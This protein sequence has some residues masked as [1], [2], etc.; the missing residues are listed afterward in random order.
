VYENIV[1][2]IKVMSKNQGAKLK[3]IDYQGKLDEDKYKSMNISIPDTIEISADFG[4]DLTE[5]YN[6][7]SKAK[8]NTAIKYYGLHTQE[9]YTD[10][11]VHAIHLKDDGN[12]EEY[13]Y[14]IRNRNLWTDDNWTDEFIEFIRERTTFINERTGNSKR[15][16]YIEVHPSKIDQFDEKPINFFDYYKKFINRI[17]EDL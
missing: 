8:K 17:A 14:L 7:V 6:C 16:K 5:F 1:V 10:D 3:L 4:R 2:E 12:R 9:P 15:L 13:R 11:K